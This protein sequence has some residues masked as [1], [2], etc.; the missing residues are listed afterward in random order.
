MH[1]RMVK[2]ERTVTPTDTL[3]MKT[4]FR[5]GASGCTEV[6]ESLSG[7][8]AVKLALSSRKLCGSLA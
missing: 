7:A 3:T 8:V 1:M 5:F 4:V 2:R 6:V